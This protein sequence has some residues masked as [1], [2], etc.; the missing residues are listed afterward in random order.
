MEVDRPA[1]DPVAARVADDH[2]AEAREERLRAKSETTEENEKA[3]LKVNLPSGAAQ[4]IDPQR[5]S[6]IIVIPV[7]GD[8]EIAGKLV[9]DADLD[10]LFRAA[11]A[12]DQTTQVIL[13]ADRAV[14]HGRVVNLMERAK[15][16]G[17]SSRVRKKCSTSSR[18]MGATW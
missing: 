15:A 6:L 2:P 9:A 7:T 16:S 17:L 14:P 5:A 4:E 1:S 3:G 13:Q 10:N 8:V 18:S 12:R 11:Y